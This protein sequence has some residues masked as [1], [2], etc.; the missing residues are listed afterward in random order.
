MPDGQATIYSARPTVRVDGAQN[1]AID[2]NIC[3]MLLHEQVGG[4]SSLE[5]RLFDSSTGPTGVESFGFNSGQ[6]LKLGAELRMYAGAADGPQ[7][8]FRGLI[9]AIE[10]ETGLDGPPTFTV[11]AEDALQKA[12]RS[13]VSATYENASPADVVNAV[14]QRL[15]IP[16]NVDS[17]LDAPVCTWL[18]MNETDLSFLRRVLTLCDGD[19]QMVGDTLQVGP[20]AAGNRGSLDLTN[21]QNLRR[22]R[23]TADLADVAASVSVAGWDPRQG[24]AVS[25]VASAGALGLGG[26]RAGKDLVAQALGVPCTE[27]IGHRG[28]MTQ[29]EAEI[30]SR[31]AFSARARR[32]VRA[33]GTADGDPR[34]RVGTQ[35]RLL[36]VN[37]LL[38]TTAIV[39]EA[40]HRF[41][42][43]DGY[44]TDFVAESAFMGR[45]S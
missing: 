45:G 37:A 35:L 4:L 29:H 40:T 28:E 43:T 18:Q 1:D 10:G 3:G 9:S 36:G 31:A 23:I 21:G 34:L 12:R 14:A 30:V 25:S 27:R 26:G 11:L 5:I 33:H 32:F 22:A 19:L 7:E 41:D 24:S 16:V 6:V 38:S 13:R 42:L 17:G 39:V 15:G 8:I 44:V 20:R 2:A